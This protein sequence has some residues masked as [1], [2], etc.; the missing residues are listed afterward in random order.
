MARSDRVVAQDPW[1]DVHDVIRAGILSGE[2]PEGSRLVEQQLADRFGTSRG[3]VRTALQELER[4]GLVVSIDRRGTFVRSIEASD[5]EEIFSLW[6]VIFAFAVRR[7]IARITPEDREWLKAF[8]DQDP[9]D[10]ID[11]VMERGDQLGRRIFEI[12]QHKRAMEIYENLFVQ[13]QARSLTIMSE[14]NPDTRHVQ[15]DFEP[16]IDALLAGDAEA[17]IASSAAWDG[18]VRRYWKERL[19]A[20]VIPSQ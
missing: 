8:R 16:L 11:A 15:G 18:E 10:D 7:A 13:A 12:A 3:P 19:G 6:D 14:A 9:P 20:D 2:F 4:S 1:R 5:V 17:A